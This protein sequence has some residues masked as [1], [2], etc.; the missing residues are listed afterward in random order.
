LQV[1]ECL[2]GSLLSQQ[3]QL[4]RRTHGFSN[5]LYAPFLGHN[6]SYIDYTGDEHGIIES[7]IARYLGN[8]NVTRKLGWVLTGEVGVYTRYEPDTVR[9]VDVIFISRKRLA[10]PSGKALQVAPE[11]VVEI[12]S[13]TDRWSEL[14]SKIA[15]YFAIGVERVWIVEPGKKQLLVYRTP[16]EFIQLAEQETV[17]GEGILEGF[18]LPLHELFAELP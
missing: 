18:A 6:L 7:E 5:S 3:P 9:G 13:P 17:H 2:L 11:L 14:R 1:H 12:V 16:T 8:F 4:Y 15:E 10:A